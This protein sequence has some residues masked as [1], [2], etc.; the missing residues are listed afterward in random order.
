MVL[1]DQESVSKQ[2]KLKLKPQDEEKPRWAEATKT[3]IPEMCWFFV[4]L[5]LLS[6]RRPLLF[7]STTSPLTSTDLLLQSHGPYL[8][9]TWTR[10]RKP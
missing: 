2:R 10:S 7:Y 1:V 9:S 8:Q 5:F 6:L 3:A 4:G